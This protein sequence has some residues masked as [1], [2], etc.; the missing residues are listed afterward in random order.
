MKLLCFISVEGQSLDI[1]SHSVIGTFGETTTLTWTVQKLMESDKIESATLFLGKKTGGDILFRGAVN[2]VS[3][4][5]EA[6]NIFGERITA[7]WSG[8]MYN[9]E[10][11]KLQYSDTFSFTLLVTQTSEDF[12]VARNRTFSTISITKVKGM[13]IFF[14]PLYHDA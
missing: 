7:N 8:L 14:E 5:Q 13:F 10:L 11:K 4:L 12:S 9:V 3:K 2:P 6:S 1:S